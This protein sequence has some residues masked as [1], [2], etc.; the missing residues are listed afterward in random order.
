MVVIKYSLSTALRNIRYVLCKEQKSRGKPKS[1]KHSLRGV[2]TRAAGLVHGAGRGWGEELHC[3][4]QWCGLCEKCYLGSQLCKQPFTLRFGLRA[5]RSRS[6]SNPFPF[7]RQTAS[8]PFQVP[9]YHASLANSSPLYFPPGGRISMLKR[10]SV[11]PYELGCCE[12][13]TH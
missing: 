9:P 11:L 2:K 3:D 6:D 5:K 12:I 10:L 7:Q 8:P 1:S 13:Y 4:S